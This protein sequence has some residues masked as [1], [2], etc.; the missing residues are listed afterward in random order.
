MIVILWVY[1]L[2]RRSISSI[3]S[4]HNS[5]YPPRQTNCRFFPLRLL[6]CFFFLLCHKAIMSFCKSDCLVISHVL[7]IGIPRGTLV[8]CGAPARWGECVCVRIASVYLSLWV[9][10]CGLV[11]TGALPRSHTSERCWSNAKRCLFIEHTLTLTA[12]QLQGSY[13]WKDWSRVILCFS[14]FVLQC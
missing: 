9:P 12:R 14:G 1:K 11:M 4:P 2:W 7:A 10:V 6:Q 5:T 13:S 3:T 8:V